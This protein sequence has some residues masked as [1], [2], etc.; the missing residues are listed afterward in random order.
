MLGIIGKLFGSKKSE[1]FLEFEDVKDNPV[2]EKVTEVAEKVAEAPEKV[3]EAV[4]KLVDEAPEKAAKIGK[5]KPPKTN[6]PEAELAK[7]TVP[8]PQPEP[9]KEKEIPPINSIQPTPEGMTFS[10]SYLMPKP[11]ASRRRPGPSLNM[12]KDMARQVGR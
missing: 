1:Y 11:T 2:V 4:Q 6:P 8:V 9:P 10:T 12:F 7:S 3:A 5:S